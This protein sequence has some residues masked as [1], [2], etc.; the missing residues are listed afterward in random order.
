MAILDIIDAAEPHLERPL[1]VFS[2]S[3]DSNKSEIQEKAQTIWLV[4]L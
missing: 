2:M 1:V 4:I 3:H